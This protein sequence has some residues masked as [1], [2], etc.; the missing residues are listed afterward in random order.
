MRSVGIKKEKRRKDEIRRKMG[1]REGKK[2]AGRPAPPSGGI[3]R[4]YI[5]SGIITTHRQFGFNSVKGRQCKESVLHVLLPQAFIHYRV[6]CL[7]LFDCYSARVRF[8]EMKVTENSSDSFFYFQ[9][10][11]CENEY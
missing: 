6:I 8:R 9:I 10:W 3:T 7:G 11:N 4:V 5:S 1:E 2:G